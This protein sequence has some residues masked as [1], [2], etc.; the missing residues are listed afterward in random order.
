M[1][2]KNDNEPDFAS[3]SSSPEDATLAGL[4]ASLTSVAKGATVIFAGLI[5]GNV[6]GMVNQII[7]G[8]FLGPE[9][10]GLFNLSMSVVMIGGTLCVFGFFGSLP[11]IIPFHM[12]KQERS[13]VR[14]V[15][16]FSS[17]F[18]FA[19]GIFFAVVTYLLSDR[20]AVDVFHDPRL[21]PALKIF[22]FAIPL[23][24]LHQVAQGAVRG[25][26]AAR[27]EA[28]VFSI[29]SRIVT[30]SV[31]LLSLSVIQRLWGAIIA[32][33][34]GLLVTTVIAFWLIWRRVFNDYRKLP[35]VPVARGVLSFT[36]P[37]AL[38]GLTF[39]FVTKT[40]KVMLGYFLTSEDVG[41]YTP[42]VVVAS[43]LEFFNSAFK[44]RFLPTASEYFSRNDV[45]GLSP[46]FKSTSKW[47]FLVVY[48][49]FL[50]ILVFPKEILTL[51][52]GS[53]YTAGYVALIVLS[54]GIAVNDF[55]GTS[56]NILV[57]GG[58]TKL[59][60]A[61]EI[62]AAVTNIGL[63][64][65]LIPLYG[66]VGAAIATGTSYVTRNIASLCF[67]YRYYGML[68]YTRKYLNVMFSGLVAIAIIYA[69]KIY[70]PLSWWATMFVLGVLFVGLYLAAT[71]LSR[72]F[73]RNDIVV[74]EAIQKRTGI[75]LDFINKLTR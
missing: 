75:R 49:I 74:F 24:G 1:K 40:D 15:L 60:L 20:L 11:R 7:L 14:S 3:G 27:Y 57:A 56:A 72:S 65:L 39:L 5:A 48:P 38:T 22:S 68:P 23:N 4:N 69:L 67:V 52:Y 73:D 17:V 31:F 50:F 13:V 21:A 58:R 34:A 25:F 8:R 9:D 10:Y 53:E 37:I 32:F 35:R 66:I 6:L 63:N 16:D 64:V 28:L 70:S 59:N 44:Y 47:S 12:R 43:L 19:L 26:K 46:L 30:I 33:M 61:C 41:I 18:S 45:S 2:T 36:W 55:S 42:A 29:G 71:L 62:I 51:L 54:M